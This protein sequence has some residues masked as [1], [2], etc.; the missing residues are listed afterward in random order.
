[1]RP[2]GVEW[3]LLSLWAVGGTWFVLTDY[4]ARIWAQIVRPVRWIERK[5][6]R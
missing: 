3:A 2:E 5:V 6:S 1:M 4:P